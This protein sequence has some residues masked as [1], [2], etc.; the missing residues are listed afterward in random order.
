MLVH[1]HISKWTVSIVVLQ[2]HT[3]LLYVSTVCEITTPQ[4]TVGRA[5]CT[6]LWNESSQGYNLVSPFSWLATWMTYWT[7][8]GPRCLLWRP[9]VMLNHQL[10]GFS[11]KWTAS[12][13]HVPNSLF[14]S[15][16]KGQGS[17]CL[18]LQF[19]QILFQPSGKKMSFLRSHS[20]I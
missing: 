5:P 4:G 2:T 8:L 17:G 6:G 13:A 14:L 3:H 15:P 19:S 12:S 7:S 11:W 18:A 1:I 9:G 20:W 10:C 16:S